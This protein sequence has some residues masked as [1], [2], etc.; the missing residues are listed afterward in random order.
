MENGDS[1]WQRLKKGKAVRRRRRVFNVWSFEWRRLS[2]NKPYLT[3]RYLVSDRSSQY[4]DLDLGALTET[5]V[6]FKRIKQ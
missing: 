6:V 4:L 3:A 5:S 1:L 2:R